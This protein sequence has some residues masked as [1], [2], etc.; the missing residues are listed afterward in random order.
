M[1]LGLPLVYR[2]HITHIYIHIRLWPFWLDDG[3]DL[4]KIG[5]I[6]IAVKEQTGNTKLI[7]FGIRHHRRYPLIDN[8]P[9]SSSFLLTLCDCC[10]QSLLS[11]QEGH[12]THVLVRSLTRCDKY[13]FF[14]SPGEKKK[15][16]LLLD[17]PSSHHHHL[18]FLLCFV[19]LFEIQ[20][21]PCNVFFGTR[22]QQCDTTAHQRPTLLFGKAHTRNYI[23]D[24]P[25][26]LGLAHTHTRTRADI[27]PMW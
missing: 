23:S 9:W 5:T 27:P 13:P 11:Q 7:S 6:V 26:R 15:P 14:L 10:P 4:V 2:L 8:I 25:Q 21:V 18:Q 24:T 3:G 16:T 12:W 22:H 20:V 1:S 19:C 17:S